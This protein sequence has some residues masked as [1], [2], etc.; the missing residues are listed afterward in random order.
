MHVIALLEEQGTGML[1][2]VTARGTGDAS[3]HLMQEAFSAFF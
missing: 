2:Q 3:E 1:L